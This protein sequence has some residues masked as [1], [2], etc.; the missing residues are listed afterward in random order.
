[1]WEEIDVN[2]TQWITRFKI[3]EDILSP[4]FHNNYVNIVSSEEFHV[5]FSSETDMYYLHINGVIYRDA[6]L[7]YAKNEEGWYDLTD[8]VF[9][10]N[11]STFL[12]NITNWTLTEFEW[13]FIQSYTIWEKEVIL[14]ETNTH[15]TV[16]YLDDWEEYKLNLN[17]LDILSFWEDTLIAWETRIIEKG[18]NITQDTRFTDI[19][20]PWSDDGITI[21][22]RLKEIEDFNTWIVVTVQQEILVKWDYWYETHYHDCV[23]YIPY[24]SKLSDIDISK[25]SFKWPSWIKRYG[26]NWNNKI[27]PTTTRS[28]YEA[29]NDI[30]MKVCIEKDVGNRDIPITNFYS[31]ERKQCLIRW[32]TRI[33]D[34][35][36][37]ETWVSFGYSTPKSWPH[38]FNSRYTIH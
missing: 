32:A 22:G 19:L 18:V 23:Y 33:Q 36:Q 12:L 35:Q 21:E 11:D 4:D 1:M 15:A 37:D 10:N 14:I 2:I 24:G 9:D 6:E 30:I 28:Y 8:I 34:F 13:N 5:Y 26:I 38:M 29:G 17:I 20:I 16:Y 31:L 27:S 3:F 25:P 7:F